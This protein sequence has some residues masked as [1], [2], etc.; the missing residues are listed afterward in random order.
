M[1]HYRHPEFMP[2]SSGSFVRLQR[3]LRRPD[4]M[5]SDSRTRR[6]TGCGTPLR[7]RHWLMVPIEVASELAGHASI[8][9]KSLYSTQ[10]LARKIKAVQGMKRRVVNG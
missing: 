6:H 3:R 5:H 7:D 1:R 2:R 10:E 9:T 4:W 8:D